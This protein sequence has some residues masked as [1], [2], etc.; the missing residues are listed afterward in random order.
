M[1]R[2]LFYSKNFCG[3]NVKGGLEVATC[4]IADAIKASGEWEVYNAFLSK[5]DGKEKSVYKDVIKLSRDAVR[6]ENQLA[7]FI[8]G[9]EIDVVVNMS[10]FFRH[11]LLIR[12]SHKSGK[13]VKIIFMHHFAPGSENKKGTYASGFHLL[14]LNPFNPVYWLRASVYPLLKLYR[15][16]SIGKIYRKVYEA[17]DR[18]VLLSQNYIRPYKEIAGLKDEHKF[19]AIPNI[20]DCKASYNKGDFR[21]MKRV[22]VLSRMDEIQKRVSL[23]LHIWARIEKEENIHD[24][25]LDVVGSG[26]DFNIMKRLAKKLKLEN[27]TFHGWKNNRSFLEQSSVLMMT[28]EYEGLPLSILE[29]QSYGCV[30][31]AFNSFG[32]LTDIIRDNETGVVVENF[33]DVNEYAKRLKELMICEDKRNEIAHRAMFQSETFTSETIGKKWCLM[34]ESIFNNDF[35]NE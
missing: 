17:S 35:R 11:K 18:V 16:K 29:A 30:P 32:S 21:K 23:A 3:E 9:N 4:R 28:S 33:G 7:K 8:A 6:F 24:W 10:R 5:S 27:T 12:A 34:L 14:R 1:K 13:N 26:H 25:H 22:L 15:N 20:Y 2:I 31:V 19:V